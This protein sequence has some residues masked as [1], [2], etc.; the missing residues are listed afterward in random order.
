MGIILILLCALLTGGFAAV[1]NLLKTVADAFV[2]VGELLLTMAIE[3]P[4]ELGVTDYLWTKGVFVGIS[5][6]AYAAAGYVFTR[7]EK[8]RLLGIIGTAVGL[9]S[10]VF[11]FV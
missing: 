11:A 9:V 6:L 7:K 8:K 10:T 4:D 5:I 3:F 2:E 1:W